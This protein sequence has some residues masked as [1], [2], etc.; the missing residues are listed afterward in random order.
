MIPQLITEPITH[1]IAISIFNPNRPSPDYTASN[2][3]TEDGFNL[4]QENGSFILLEP[5][6]YGEPGM[7]G[8]TFMVGINSL[9]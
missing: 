8:S 6:N 4:L 1:S 9:A 7:I 3:E 2:L 5:S